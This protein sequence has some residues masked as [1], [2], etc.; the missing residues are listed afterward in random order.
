MTL[1]DKIHKG[2]K[3]APR[4]I[5]LYGIQG[6]GKSTFAAMSEKPTFIQT[7]EGLNEI[8]C[9]SFPL[10]E[11]YEQIMESVKELYQEKHNYKTVVIDSLDWAERMIWLYVCQNRNVDSIED[12]GYGK[13]YMYAEDPWRNMLAGLDVLRKDRGMTIILIA[14]S[15]I[16][17]FENP[18]TDTYIRYAPRLHKLAAAM[19][20]EWCDEVL[21]ASYKVHTKQ[22]DE[23]FNK[24]RTQGIGTGERILK[25]EERPS[26]VAKNRL[27][28]PHEL[29]LD[30]RA[31]AQFVQPEKGEQTK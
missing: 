25:T 28:L 17:K 13:G 31:Y 4:R 12:F 14:H 16:E 30:W 15:K 22:T 27:N 9:E 1:L 23:G 3:I 5:M 10:V 6:I 19:I 26:Y 11:T 7:E 18:E 21:F 8:D 20:Q 24:K 2:K 29:P